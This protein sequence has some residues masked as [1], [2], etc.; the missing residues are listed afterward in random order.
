MK[1]LY[2]FHSFI[3]E[4]DNWVIGGKELTDDE[5]ARIPKGFEHTV[6]S[7]ETLTSISQKY[8]VKDKVKGILE[9]NPQYIKN[10]DLIKPGEKVIIGAGTYK[11]KEWDPEKGFIK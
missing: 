3:C 8:G 7:G 11:T 5:M 4:G 1:H 6:K 2:E 9:F 10:P